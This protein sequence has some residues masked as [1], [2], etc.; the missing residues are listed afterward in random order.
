MPHMSLNGEVAFCVQ[1]GRNP[2]N[3]DSYTP[4]GE[5]NDNRIKQILANYDNSAQGDEEYAAAQVAIWMYKMGLSTV[6]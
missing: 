2:N 1:W 3:G 4:S 5:G 6:D